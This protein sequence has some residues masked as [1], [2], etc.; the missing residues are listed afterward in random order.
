MITHVARGNYQD[1][2]ILFK[3]RRVSTLFKKIIDDVRRERLQDEKS[4]CDQYA[5][6]RFKDIREVKRLLSFGVYAPAFAYCIEHNLLF[7][8]FDYWQKK[9]DIIEKELFFYYYF[10]AEKN[11][12]EIIY[13]LAWAIY[14]NADAS[15]HLLYALSENK[16]HM[17][18]RKKYAEKNKASF[19]HYKCLKIRARRYTPCK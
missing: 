16:E 15:Q 5:Q 2:C 8:L 6:A 13:P 14:Q 19:E 10:T 11:T 18:E 1:F 17:Q 7:S 4:L 9:S 12:L 3:M